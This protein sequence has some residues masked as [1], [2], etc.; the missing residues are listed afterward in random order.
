MFLH[1]LLYRLSRGLI[2]GSIGGNPILL[3]ATIGRRSGKQYTIPLAYVPDEG[4]YLVIASAMGAPKHPAWY[5][6]LLAHPHTTIEV[7]NA[8]IA[9]EASEVVGAERQRVWPKLLAA[10]PFLPRHEQKAQRTI[11]I[12]RLRPR[13]S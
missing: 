4:A 3:L 1:T 2:G 12:I 10:A 13:S 6:N 8:R 9:V 7:K 5:F 11:P